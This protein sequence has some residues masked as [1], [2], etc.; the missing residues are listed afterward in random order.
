[1]DDIPLRTYFDLST[2]HITS[3][4]DNLLRKCAT[5]PSDEEAI[6]LSIIVDAMDQGWAVLVMEDLKEY[7]DYAALAKFGFSLAFID[8]VRL[9]VRKGI[10][11]IWFD[12]DA[13]IVPGLPTFSWG[14]EDEWLSERDKE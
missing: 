14:S 13:P 9:V 6:G 7:R 3:E 4:D 2:A 1:M 12:A 5:D 11:G 10:K 8:L